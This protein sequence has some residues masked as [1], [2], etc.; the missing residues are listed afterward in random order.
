MPAQ[1]VPL[2]EQIAPDHLARGRRWHDVLDQRHEA[3]VADPP[4]RLA[5][6]APNVEEHRVRLE[7]QVLP[8]RCAECLCPLEIVVLRAAVPKPARERS[9]GQVLAQLERTRVRRQDGV[10]LRGVIGECNVVVGA[11]GQ[12]ILPEEKPEFCIVLRPLTIAD[13]LLQLLPDGPYPL[14]V[15]KV[16]R[17]NH[18]ALRKKRFDGKASADRPQSLGRDTPG[19]VA[20][21]IN[22]GGEIHNP[23]LE[24][25]RLRGILVRKMAADEKAIPIPHLPVVARGNQVVVFDEALGRPYGLWFKLHVLGGDIGEQLCEPPRVGAGS[26]GERGSHAQCERQGDDDL[27]SG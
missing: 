2:A 12:R 3:R 1:H 15:A 17:G 4:D 16:L 22:R 5:V 25:L 21:R 10:A 20:I 8:H 7:P 27:A 13:D 6:G 14:G 23:E 26:G 9:H 24:V 18:R 19:D 11:R